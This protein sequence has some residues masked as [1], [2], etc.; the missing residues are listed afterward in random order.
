MAIKS[1]NG[2]SDGSAG[3]TFTCPAC[4]G[5]ALML[6]NPMEAQLVKGMGVHVGLGA[7]MTPRGPMETIESSLQKTAP[8][9]EVEW[10]MDARERLMRVPAIARPMAKMAIERHARKSGARRVTIELMDE[11]KK[12]M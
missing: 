1:V 7:A 2:D 4:G 12:H 10:A 11:V 8:D 5:G 3:I 9:E 6:I